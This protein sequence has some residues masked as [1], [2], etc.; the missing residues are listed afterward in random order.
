MDSM[1]SQP[2]SNKYSNF[3]VTINTNYRP[4]DDADA[5]DKRDRLRAKMRYLLSSAGME[6]I[7]AFP[8]GEGNYRD[9]VTTVQNDFAVEMGEERLLIH[10]H[11]LIRITHNSYIRLDREA[12]RQIVGQDLIRDG[13]FRNC[14]I[15]IKSV[16]SHMYLEDYLKKNMGKPFPSVQV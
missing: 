12:I 10:S 14:H 6:K 15:D 11:A 3:L 8:K 13:E 2:L 5:L 16:K 1:E 4:V 7:I 9:N